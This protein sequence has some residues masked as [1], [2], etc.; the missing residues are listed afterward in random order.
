M[1]SAVKSVQRMPFSHQPTPIAAQRSTTAPDTS[2]Y[3]KGWEA[4]TQLNADWLHGLGFTG[5]GMT[6]AVLDAGFEN[7]E[8][9]PI[10]QKAW[11]E[12][13]IIEGMD[14]M[15]SQGGLF[16]H[17][18]HGTACIGNDGGVFTPTLS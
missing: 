15:Q 10:F 8:S 6:I 3:G 12:G 18:R 9:L 13:R 11:D 2:W 16:A 14:A 5:Q 1:V 17:H 7:V 4:L